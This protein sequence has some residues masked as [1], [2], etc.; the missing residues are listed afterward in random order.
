MAYDELELGQSTR[1]S[2]SASTVASAAMAMGRLIAQFNVGRLPSP[3][4]AAA[5]RAKKLETHLLGFGCELAFRATAAPTVR[6]WQPALILNDRSR[7]RI[8]A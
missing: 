1:D 7:S 2:F 3:T 6:S 5:G 4:L 8:P